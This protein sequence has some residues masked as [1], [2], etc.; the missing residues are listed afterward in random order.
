MDSEF[1]PQPQES[2]AFEPP[3]R[4]PPTAVGTMEL[5]PPRPRR[6]DRFRR[7][8]LLLRIALGVFAA[9]LVTAGG[10]LLWPLG[11]RALAGVALVGAGQ[12]VVRRLVARRASSVEM[13]AP[14]FGESPSEVY[15]RSA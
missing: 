5:P 15:V 9:L 14:R 12:Y 11:W 4:K 7:L 6:G 8:P 1:E 2:G 3:R 10:V 13:H